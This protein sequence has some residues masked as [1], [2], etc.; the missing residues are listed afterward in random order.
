MTAG[1][2]RARFPADG[3]SA[4]A[5]RRFVLAKLTERERSELC[6]SSLVLVT[7]LVSNAVLHAGTELE[8]VVRRPD[9]RL[10]VEVH[11]GSALLPVRKH[12]SLTA[13]TGRGLV[14]VEEM[15]DRWGAETTPT[16]KVVWFELDTEARAKDPLCEEM[17]VPEFD[18]D[19]FLAGQ[20]D[21]EEG[22][23][24]P[25]ADFRHRRDAADRAELV[26]S[27]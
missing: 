1:E 22:N 16:G 15:A 25:G 12:Y 13:A 2:A 24:A 21:L 6:D 11:D 19:E 27:R 10:R 4:A 18:L 17:Q 14:L 26:A 3:S 5:A 23:S 20:P 7:E 9:G 8:V